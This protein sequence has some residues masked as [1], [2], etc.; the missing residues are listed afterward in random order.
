MDS[1]KKKTAAII[2][3]VLSVCFVG[4]AAFV[5]IKI[6]NGFFA[7]SDYS[8]E[9]GTTENTETTEEKS[10]SDSAKT[11]VYQSDGFA[12]L[13]PDEEFITLPSYA[14]YDAESYRQQLINLGVKPENILVIDREYANVGE[15]LAADCNF[16]P[17]DQVRITDFPNDG[18]RKAQRI[19]VYRAVPPKT[20]DKDAAVKAVSDILPRYYYNYLAGINDQSADYLTDATE[21]QYEYL[22]ERIFGKDNKGYNFLY[23]RIVLDLDTVEVFE[24]D[25]QTRVKFTAKFQFNQI[26]LSTGKNSANFN[27]QIIEIVYE[28]GVWLVDKSEIKNSLK[29]GS[30][31]KEL[32]YK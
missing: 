8:D 30:N 5:G 21:N 22:K 19:I 9:D 2:A 16:N 24:S 28:N 18:T 15:G 20:I 29:I 4:I 17:G 25:G 13:T 3:A 12:G 31:Q 1:K 11:D 27:T 32:Y 14:D 6:Y 10:E 7:G 26:D 23:D